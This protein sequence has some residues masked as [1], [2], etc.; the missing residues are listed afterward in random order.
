MNA[1]KGA[2]S[3]VGEANEGLYL[4]PEVSGMTTMLRAVWPPAI[5]IIGSMPIVAAVAA[6]NANLDPFSA[7]LRT[8]IGAGV[9]CF[10]VGGWVRQRDAIHRWWRQAIAG[11]KPQA[12]SS[13]K[14]S[15]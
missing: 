4:P 15:S 2:P 5:A 14:G 3:Q 10:L 6:R 9:V 1:V 12:S 7:A 13:V 8:A 11:S